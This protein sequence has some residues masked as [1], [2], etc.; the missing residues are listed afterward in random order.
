MRDPYRGVYGDYTPLTYS[1]GS[2]VEAKHQ[3]SMMHKANAKVIKTA[4]ETFKEGIVKIGTAF[5][6]AFGDPVLDL[7]EH[8]QFGASDRSEWAGNWTHDEPSSDISKAGELE[9][10]RV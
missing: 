4:A 8:K 2:V 7:I 3:K 1:I 5:Q 10:N 6:K 9:A